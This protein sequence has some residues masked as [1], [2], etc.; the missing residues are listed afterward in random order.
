MLLL[1]VLA[2][3]KRLNALR[4]ITRAECAGV[5]RRRRGHAKGRCVSVEIFNQLIKRDV[6]TDRTH[7]NP[8]AQPSPP[9][10]SP[11]ASVRRPSLMRRLGSPTVSCISQ[12]R[13][14]GLL[15]LLRAELPPPP[16]PTVLLHESVATTGAWS[17]GQVSSLT[18]FAFATSNA[19]LERKM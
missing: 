12:S 10:R 17:D 18:T 1:C 19:F 16:P 15:L 6:G 9:R 2:L 13:F 11:L 14:A 7:Y 4:C 8:R 3:V 5:W